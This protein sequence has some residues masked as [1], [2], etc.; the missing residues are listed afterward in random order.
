MTSGNHT[1]VIPLG[2]SAWDRTLLARKPHGVVIVSSNG[3]SWE[4]YQKSMSFLILVCCAE[5]GSKSRTLPKRSK[6]L[7]VVS[8]L[9]C[10]GRVQNFPP[11]TLARSF[12]KRDGTGS[13]L[14]IVKKPLQMGSPDAGTTRTMTLSLTLVWVATVSLSSI[15]PP[16]LS[17]HGGSARQFQ[18]KD[19]LPT[20]TKLSDT[21]HSSS[22][23]SSFGRTW[24]N[25]ARLLNDPRVDIWYVQELRREVPLT[26][27]RVN[28]SRAVAGAERDQPD[29]LVRIAGLL[30]NKIWIDR[31]ACSYSKLL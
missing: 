8:A 21:G 27:L 13:L 18:V 19:I 20:G 29:E 24:A 2:C 14:R 6:T 12:L 22:T 28:V 3:L 16:P 4:K 17:P 10:S 9:S 11:S 7:G 1:A 5:I 26:L 25:R 30:A 31:R 23:T 15:I